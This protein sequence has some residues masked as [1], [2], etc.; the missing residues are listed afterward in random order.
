MKHWIWM[1][2]LLGACAASQ[3]ADYYVSPNGNDSNPGNDAAPFATLERAQQA[4]RALVA[5]GLDHDVEVLLHGG[6]YLLERA[7]VF[8]PQDS[9]TAEHSI[10]WRAVQGEVAVL[11]GG[12][13][14]TGWKPIGNNQW[15]AAVPGVVEGGWS[16]RQLFANGV[17]LPRGRHPNAPDLLRVESVSEDVK[18]VVMEQPF[19]EVDL[20]G[21]N[22]ELVMYQNWSISRVSILSTQERSLSLANPMGWIGHGPM[23]T[24]SPGKPAYVEHVLQYVDVPGE[25]Y[26][27]YAKGV[28]TY[29]A[30]QD[31]DPNGQRFVAPYL[32]KLL[33]VEGRSEAPVLNLHFEGLQFKY[34]RWE[35]PEFG[36]LG[37]QAGHY[38][39]RTVDPSH[40]LPAA[41]EFTYAQDCTIKNSRIAHTGACGVVFGAGC[42]R[43]VV[44]ACEITDIGGNGVMVGWRGKGE[45]E[46]KDQG[47]DFHL[48]GD[49][50]H[51]E[52]VPVGNRVIGSLVSQCGAVNHGCVGIFAAFSDGT[53]IEQNVVYDMPYTGISVGFRWDSTDTSQKNAVIAHNHVH[54]TMKMLADGGCLYTLGYQPG[55]VIRGNVFH[56]AHR[57]GFAHGGA[58]NNGI[59]FD[60]GSKG[61]HVVDNTIYNTSGEAIRFNQTNA[62]NFTWEN[63]SFGVGPGRKVAP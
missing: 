4:V 11:S 57:S 42:R 23:T 43:N 49:W 17:R 60:E 16:I 2:A 27:D 9:G 22:A 54:D 8:D 37:I 10:T 58:P 48:A 33:V 34:T 12:K 61:F 47:G 39:T 1:A 62:E 29:Q 20:A 40:V 41:L 5:A 32:S 38:G 3:A 53:R 6:D 25:W 15:T 24:A 36:Y 31:E 7:L 55:T 26:L 46:G 59:F 14:V 21:Q 52:D 50:V 35:L 13:A 19:S 28:L 18:T 45:I 30:A 63:N 56:D 51:P 44:E